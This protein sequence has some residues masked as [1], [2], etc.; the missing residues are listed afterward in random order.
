MN[1]SG[2]WQADICMAANLHTDC[3]NGYHITYSEG[4]QASALSWRERG[5]YFLFIY[6]YKSLTQPY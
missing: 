5:I 4:S 2:R 3:M 1:D 6:H